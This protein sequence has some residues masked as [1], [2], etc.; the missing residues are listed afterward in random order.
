M[1]EG[2]APLAY[3]DRIVLGSTLLRGPQP[4]VTAPD[5]WRAVRR[6]IDGKRRV[7]YGHDW[8]SEAE[9]DDW[10]GPAELEAG[11]VADLERWGGAPFEP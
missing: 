2:P 5:D 9:A 6:I 10:L 7:W 4:P 11:A 3:T 1:A 8:L